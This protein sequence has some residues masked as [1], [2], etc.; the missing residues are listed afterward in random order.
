[1]RSLLPRSR[2]VWVLAL[3]T[4]ARSI[5]H[6]IVVTVSVLYFTYSVD[7]PAA[8]VGL[9]LTVAAVVGMVV[10]IPAGHLSDLLGAR[11]AS[12]AFVLMQGL[13]LWGYTLVGGFAGLLVAA[14]LVAV[15]ESA[16]G[17]ARGALVALAVEAPERVRTR[18]YLRSVTNVGFSLGTV[19]GGL[20][21]NHDTRTVYLAELFVGGAVFL[22]AGL[23]FLALPHLPPVPR[24]DPGASRW[25]VL[26]DRPFAVV[27]LLNAVL[28]MN[29]GILNVALPIWIAERT[30][31]PA[32]VFAALLLVNTV[33]VVLCQ[34][35]VSRGAEDIPGGARALR[36]SGLWL[37][38]CCGVFALAAGQSAWVAVGVLAVGVVLHTIGELLYSAGSWALSYELAPD[39]AQGQYQGMFGLTTQLGTA[40]TPA[41]TTVL[42]VGYGWVGWAVLA[43][44]L[45]AA[46]LAAPAVSRWAER[47][48]PYASP[49]PVEG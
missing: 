12:T 38:A 44:G 45:A 29:S 37:A 48:R 39:H 14:S 5:G 25:L 21:L 24:A 13:T 30:E 40:V 41:V 46:G 8:R 20:A 36:R 34:V 1:M 6:G 18:A 49:V 23:V 15:A 32:S 43:A 9:G 11:T 28:I 16:S 22:A 42:I 27:G 4:L 35:P 31:A 47:S 2:T 19:V 3:S 10:S 17:A 26:R 33:L 7:I